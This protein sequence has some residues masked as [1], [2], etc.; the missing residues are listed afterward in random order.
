MKKNS[1][2]PPCGGRSDAGFRLYD[3]PAVRP[4]RES[5]PHLRLP[6]LDLA[7]ESTQPCGRV[8]RTLAGVG[9]ALVGF[10]GRAE[11]RVRKVAAVLVRRNRR[12]L[13]EAFRYS[14]AHRGPGT[15]AP[16]LASLRAAS[17]RSRSRD[18]T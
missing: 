13:S 14:F 11:D 4:S 7:I 10:A 16:D 6:E 12:A 1:D 15:V 3:E 17:T 2:P 8:T 5:W 18:R 9:R